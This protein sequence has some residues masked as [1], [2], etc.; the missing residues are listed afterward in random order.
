MAKQQRDDKNGGT[1]KRN[2]FK[3]PLAYAVANKQNSKQK[4]EL[5]HK[6]FHRIKLYNKKQQF[7]LFS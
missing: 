3:G 6:V 5:I 7:A 2:A 1:A 4:N